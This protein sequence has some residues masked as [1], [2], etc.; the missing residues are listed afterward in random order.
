MPFLEEVA[1]LSP[2]VPTPRRTDHRFTLDDLDL[3][4]Q[5]DITTLDLV[6]SV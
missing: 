4:R 3:S 1:A 2:K 5:I 6:L